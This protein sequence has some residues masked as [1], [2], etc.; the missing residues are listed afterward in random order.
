MFIFGVVNKS[1]FFYSCISK[2]EVKYWIH[3]RMF[4]KVAQQCC[5]CNIIII[6]KKLSLYFQSETCTIQLPELDMELSHSSEGGKF[7]TIEGLIGNL[8]EGVCYYFTLFV[9]S[10]VIHF[11]ECM[12]RPYTLY[13]ISK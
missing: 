5:M 1:S 12:Q 3:K 11:I 6:N 4:L 2:K 9:I 7:T 10:H 8:Q 13:Y